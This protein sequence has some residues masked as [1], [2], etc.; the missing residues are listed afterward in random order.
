MGNP[1]FQNVCPQARQAAAPVHG[2]RLARAG[3][4]VTSVLG[5]KQ[6]YDQIM[7]SGGDVGKIMDAVLKAPAFKSYNG[8]RDPKSMVEFGCQICGL[9]VS[10]IKG[11]AQQ[12]G[13]S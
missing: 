10:D 9:D 6:A 11:Y 13:I 8:P 3:S 7:A 1:F 4:I 2:G 12:F 5:A